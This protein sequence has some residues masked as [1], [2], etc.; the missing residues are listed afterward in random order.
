MNRSRILIVSQRHRPDG[1]GR[2]PG[3]V[4]FPEGEDVLAACTDAD[5][6][7]VDAD[8]THLGIRAWRLVGRTTRR[9]THSDRSIA[10]RRRPRTTSAEPLGDHYDVAVFVGFTAWDLPLLEGVRNLSHLA[11][12][13]IVWFP[14]V[15]PS[16]FDDRRLH[17]EPFAIADA[18]FVG[19]KGTAERL[20]GIAP[21][22]VHHV[23][24]AVDVTRF[25][26]TPLEPSR[27]IDVLGIGRRDA[28][29]HQALLDWSRKSH[30]LYVY[31]TLAG[32][33]VLDT[34][35]HRENLGDTYRRTDLAI[36]NYAKYDVPSVI[37]D[38]RETPGRLWEG[39]AS[40]AFMIG[41]PPDE[42]LQRELIGES[43]VTP[44]PPSPAA[45]VDLIDDLNRADLEGHRRHQV[46][47]ALRGHDWIHRWTKIFS[48]AGIEAPEGFATR[49]RQLDAMAASLD[50]VDAQP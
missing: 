44:L 11:D 3:Y 31:D 6:A 43:V 20:A 36:T 5:F 12:K 41:F 24:P 23:P 46:Q 45:A 2:K 40:G 27:P 18:I 26:A 4:S 28:S 30:K 22:P 49:R 50:M 21:C 19:I 7:M 13:V 34:I 33:E 14:E 1:F 9:V 29:L 37:G 15:W 42:L 25:A 35:A 32:A 10:S 47:L 8:P 16:E 48:L 39:L 38:Q 17:H